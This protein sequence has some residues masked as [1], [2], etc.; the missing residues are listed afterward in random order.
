MYKNTSEAVE[1]RTP[2]GYKCGY[3]RQ[4]YK[5]FVL[6]SDL[7]YSYFKTLNIWKALIFIQHLRQTIKIVHHAKWVY[8]PTRSASV[9]M[10]GL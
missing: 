5:N 2:Q 7:F 3:V 10:S 1:L 9:F 6:L 4:R 8:T